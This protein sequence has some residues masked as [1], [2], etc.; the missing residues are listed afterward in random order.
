MAFTV[1][2]VML[3]AKV[4]EIRDRLTINVCLVSDLS[5]RF[6]KK[7]GDIVSIPFAVGRSVPASVG[8]SESDISSLTVQQIK[9]K[10][11]HVLGTHRLMCTTPLEFRSISV[12]FHQGAICENTFLLITP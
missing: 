10:L 11:P 9:L 5:P 1:L 4:T 7:W 2:Y 3:L 6:P 12:F 8:P